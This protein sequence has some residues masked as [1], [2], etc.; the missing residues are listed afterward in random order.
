[1]MCADLWRRLPGIGGRRG[2]DRGAG[3]TA[4]RAG[5]LPAGRA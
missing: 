5:D 2:N 1:M 3:P 4:A